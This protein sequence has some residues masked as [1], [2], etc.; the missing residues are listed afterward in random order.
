MLRIRVA[1][2]FERGWEKWVYIGME[3]QKGNSREKPVLE[4]DRDRGK[5][6]SGFRWG[7]T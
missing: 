4:E 6:V 3:S 1:N 5:P 2:E 7:K